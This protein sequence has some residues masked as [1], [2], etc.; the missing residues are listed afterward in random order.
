MQGETD[1]RKLENSLDYEKHFEKL[2]T[3]IR[4]DFNDD[5][6]PIIYGEVSSSTNVPEAKRALN[7]SQLNTSKTIKDTYYIRTSD[8]EMNN[9]NVHFSDNALHEFGSRFGAVLKD[10]IVLEPDN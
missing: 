7:N 1:I 10:I 8:L 2:I 4:K 5:N 3:T 6:L 9:D